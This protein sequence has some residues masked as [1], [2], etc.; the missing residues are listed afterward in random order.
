MKIKRGNGK[1]T[2]LIDREDYDFLKREKWY[3]TVNPRWK[4]IYVKRFTGKY[5]STGTPIYEDR[6]LSRFL[7]SCPEEMVVDHI[8]GNPLDNRRENLR[9]CTFIQNC[10]NK[11]RSSR[12]N[13]GTSKYRGVYRTRNKKS[14]WNV[15]IRV[16]RKLVYREVFKTE[17][18]AARAYDLKAKEIHGEYAFLNF[19]EEK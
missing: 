10:K 15:D 14:P 2:V 13:G 6:M 17:I 11:V 12:N 8:N 9:I 7:M 18:L 3:M 19:P 1:F 4:R 16:N 5:R